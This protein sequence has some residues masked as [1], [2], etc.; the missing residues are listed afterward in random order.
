MLTSGVQKKN[1]VLRHSSRQLRT[2]GEP[3]YTLIYDEYVL[4][5]RLQVKGLNQTILAALSSF[6][7]SLVSLSDRYEGDIH[8]GN[9][10]K[11]TGLI[12]AIGW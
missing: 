12:C 5:L 11:V 10:L 7:R 9:S 3:S 6:M 2:A 8:E 1:P 4:H